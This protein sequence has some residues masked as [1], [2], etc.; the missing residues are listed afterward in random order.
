M[1]Y[2]HAYVFPLFSHI[3][4]Y[5]VVWR[6]KLSDYLSRVAVLCIYHSCDDDM[7]VQK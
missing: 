7:R 4:H 1:F 2:S 6:F 3:K 5:D